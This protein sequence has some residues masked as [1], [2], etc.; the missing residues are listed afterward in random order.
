M[1]KSIRIVLIVLAAVLLTGVAA[2]AVDAASSAGTEDDPC[3]LFRRISF[4][5]DE[6]FP[7]DT[8][9]T[10]ESYREAAALGTQ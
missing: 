3:A 4:P 9:E 1:K 7:P 5:V 10:C 8:V 6:F 2:L